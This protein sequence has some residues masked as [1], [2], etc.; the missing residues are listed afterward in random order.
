MI[1]KTS[2]FLLLCAVPIFHDNTVLSNEVFF[3]CNCNIF[4]KTMK[5]IGSNFFQ[6][7]DPV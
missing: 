3:G 5:C 7:V 4:C 6:P 2:L 1:G